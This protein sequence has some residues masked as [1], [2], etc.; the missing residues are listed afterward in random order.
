MKAGSM[1][2][3]RSVRIFRAVDVSLVAASPPHDIPVF[4]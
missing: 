3:I 2:K 1:A 4:V